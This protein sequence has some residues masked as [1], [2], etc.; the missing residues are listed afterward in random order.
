VTYCGCDGQTFQGSG[1]CPPRPYSHRGACPW[2][3]A[4]VREARGSW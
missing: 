2:S 1:S 4:L 3:G